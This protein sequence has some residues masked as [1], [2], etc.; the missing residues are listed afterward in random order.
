M[1]CNSDSSESSE[2]KETRK[3]LEFFRHA[4][5]ALNHNTNGN[6]GKQLLNERN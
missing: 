2:S 3:G 4:L 5:S 6:G 1:E